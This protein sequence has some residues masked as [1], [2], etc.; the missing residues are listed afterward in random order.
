MDQVRDV[1]KL[2][3]DSGF[4]SNACGFFPS[5]PS[6]TNP[7]FS[8]STNTVVMPTKDILENDLE[9]KKMENCFRLFKWS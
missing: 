8:V 6:Q 4:K 5:T 1:R 3:I 2:P 7:I 9:T